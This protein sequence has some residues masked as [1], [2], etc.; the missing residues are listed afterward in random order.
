MIGSHTITVHIYIFILLI[1]SHRIAVH[2]YNDDRLTQGYNNTRFIFRHAT[3]R[4]FCASAI[5]MR[6]SVP[7]R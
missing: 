5:R 3:Y 1:R 2:T 4:S 7:Y 6:S